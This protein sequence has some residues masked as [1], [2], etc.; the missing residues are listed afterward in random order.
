MR[1]RGT[2]KKTSRAL[3]AR[4][5]ADAVTVVRTI[6]VVQ[7]GEIHDQGQR[8]DGGRHEPG[9]EGVEVEAFG[10][11]RGGWAGEVA[12]ERSADVVRH[13]VHPEEGGQEAVVHD[14]GEIKTR[15]TGEVFA[16]WR[17][18]QEHELADE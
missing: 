12:A 4:D 3:A 5:P 2:A 14:D 7:L 11:G 10:G 13:H 8:N 6:E 17:H 16:R 15:P 1:P 18:K 9:V